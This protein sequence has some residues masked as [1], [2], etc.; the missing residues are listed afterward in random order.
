MAEIEES[1]PV[2]TPEELRNIVLRI[3]GEH[4]FC[5]SIEVPHNLDPEDV[6]NFARQA[7]VEEGISP[8]P[9]EQLLWGY[10][11]SLEHGRMMLF[12]ASAFK[13]RQMGWQDLE[14]F[15]RVFPSFVSLFVQRIEKPTICFL[16]HEETLTA[17][18]FEPDCPV[19]T[20]LFSLPISP[21]EE[22]ENRC[23]E[24][25]GKLLSLFPLQRFE[26]SPQIV[27]TGQVSR[28]NDGFFDFEHFVEDSD[29]ENPPDEIVHLPAELLWDCDVRSLAFKQ[30]EQLR[31]EWVRRRWTAFLAW[32]V[33]VAALIVAFV[34]IRIFE[35]KALAR[36]ADATEKG[37]QVP[38]VL[39]SQKLLEKLRQNK[40]GGIDPFGAL[41]RLAAHRGGQGD[42]PHLWFTNAKF[43][44]RNDIFLVGQGRNVEAVNSFIKGLV[45]NGVGN[46]QTTKR[47]EPKRKIVSSSGKTTFEIQLLLNEENVIEQANAISDEVTQE[48]EGG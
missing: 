29:E 18:S 45:E 37:M 33:G 6:L 32:G 26:I 17:A 9:I 4:F 19:P 44:S 30:S 5:E 42:E 21:E 36:E 27:V 43:D 14:V 22:E 10:F 34:G 48:D 23:D 13:I 7:L 1:A 3:P 20:Q 16:R 15:R 47:G 41:G 46:V 40:L 11:C 35:G 28:T 31:R 2:S 38:L 24:T 12:C 25:R 39:E 8:Y